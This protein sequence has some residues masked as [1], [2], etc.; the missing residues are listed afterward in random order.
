M[1][2]YETIDIITDCYL[3][4][5]YIYEIILKYGFALIIIYKAGKTILK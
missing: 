4:K 2:C 1:E 3:E 5:S